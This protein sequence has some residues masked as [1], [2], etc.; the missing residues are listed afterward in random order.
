MSR[1][2]LA[3]GVALSAL[4]ARQV[5]VLRGVWRS[6]RFLS[7]GG[8]A[9]RQPVD[10]P[11][12][13]PT[14]FYVVLPVLRE[15]PIITSTVDHVAGL[16]KSHQGAIVV[17]TTAREGAEGSHPEDATDTADTIRVVEELA[18]AGRCIHLHHPDPTGLKADQLNLAANYCR[19][20]LG[21]NVDPSRGFLVCYDADSRPPLDSL[22]RFAR[23]VAQ[24]PDV[25]VFHQ[26]SRFELREPPGAAGR[27]PASG[28]A[29][30]IADGGA[31]RANRFVLGY[32]IPRLLNRSTL[33]GGLK[34]RLSSH[35]YAHVTGHGLCLRLSLLAA[36]PF[37][38]RSPLEDMHYSFLLGSR[39]LPMLPVPSLDRAEVP[40]SPRAQVEQAARW[41]FG[42]GRF[43]RYLHDQRTEP[44]LRARLL[45]TSALAICLEWLSCAVLPVLLV[46]FLAGGGGVVR[47]AA[48]LFVIVYAGQLVATEV[49]VGSPAPVGSRLARVVAYPVSCLLFGIGGVLGAWR[50]LRGRSGAGKTERQ[51]A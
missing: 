20:V 16:L 43:R 31:L 45:A 44:G 28:L 1:F 4:T 22:D 11:E 18:R 37:P 27:R 21:A 13:Q 6:H 17:V 2:D 24:H 19:T 29:R 42:P 39:N 34:R 23:A 14:F 9:G 8:A 50:L 32:E 15:A 7:P 10:V 30:V 5:L 12:R 49:Y 41:F 47:V 48:A 26:S 25:D 36:L 46:V 38:A 3:L 51:P 35:V 40:A 33:V